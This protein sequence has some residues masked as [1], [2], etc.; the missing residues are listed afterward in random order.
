MTQEAIR[1]DEVLRR[2]SPETRVQRAVDFARRVFR[3]RMALP[4]SCIILVVVLAAILAPVIS[5]YDPAAQDPFNGL[6]APSLS[7]P[8]GTDQLGRD[9][10]SRIIYGSRVALLIGFGAVSLGFVVGIPIGVVSGYLRGWLDDLLMRFMDAM[11][12]F[13]GLI[14]ALALVAVYGASVRNLIIAIGIANIPW[15]ARITRGQV[16]AVRELE[17]V[18]AASAL[19]AGPLRIMSTH[20]LPNILSP[21]IVQGTLAMGYAILSEAGLSFLGLGVPPPTPTWGSML[22]FAFGFMQIAP[23]LAIFPGAMIF[24]LVLSLNLLG[25]A[26][27]DVLDPRL[28][29]L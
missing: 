10:L 8:F 28:K 3:I 2:H 18:T 22:Q 5:P 23:T 9:V 6:Q 25:D 19:G 14:L 16:L 20:V 26:L 29:G 17:Y 12:A 4:A 1:G 21:L 13:P 7:H 11:I 24:L 15:I 27:R